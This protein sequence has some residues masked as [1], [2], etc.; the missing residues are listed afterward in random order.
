ML[1]IRYQLLMYNYYC[2]GSLPRYK[3][4]V[5]DHEEV[6]LETLGTVSY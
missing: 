6:K 3:Y 4:S 1:K 2:I 5:S